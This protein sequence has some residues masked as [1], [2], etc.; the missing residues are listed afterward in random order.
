M[1]PPTDL[2]TRLPRS[3]EETASRWHAEG[4]RCDSYTAYWTPEEL[5][6][7]FGLPRVLLDALVPA[8]VVSE[9]GERPETCPPPGTPLYD[10]E[11]VG[12]ALAAA[13]KVRRLRRDA[14][15]D[16]SKSESETAAAPERPAVVPRVVGLP[17]APGPGSVRDL[18]DRKLARWRSTR[19]AAGNWSVADDAG[20]TVRDGLTYEAAKAYAQA[21]LDAGGGRLSVCCPPRPLSLNA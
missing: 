11:R 13:G 3:F 12:A 21:T 7:L 8:A 19:G 2:R 9:R 17:P 1:S 5:A 6:R 14:G 4:V 20:R 16:K 10:R 18:M 15:R